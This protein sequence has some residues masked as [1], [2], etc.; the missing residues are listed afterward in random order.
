VSR[1]EDAFQIV[2]VDWLRAHG[3]FCMHV[4]NQGKWSAHYGVTL[5][6]MGRVKGAT[7]L[8]CFT[9]ISAKLPRGAFWIECKEPPKRLQDGTLSKAK[10]RTSS[11]QD[12]FIAEMGARGMPT[13]IVRDL[14]T[15]ES[16]LCNMGVLP[17]QGRG[18]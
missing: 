11:E 6:R 3:I 13:L 7:D 1:P 10:A 9:E 16:A 12:A 2:V 18:K 8:L 17:Q 15:L 14:W 4:K 5:N